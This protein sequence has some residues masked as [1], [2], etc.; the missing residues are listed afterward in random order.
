ME[1]KL[2]TRKR[3]SGNEVLIG[4]ELREYPSKL[5]LHVKTIS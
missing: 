3:K 4:L 5:P 2:R 1:E